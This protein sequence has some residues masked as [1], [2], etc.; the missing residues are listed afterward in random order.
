MDADAENLPPLQHVMPSAEWLRARKARLAEEAEEAERA[1]TRSWLDEL[2]ARADAEIAAW[3]TYP[4]NGQLEQVTACADAHAKGCD[5]R[6][7]DVCPR[8][9]LAEAAREEAWKRRAFRGDL[10]RAGVPERALQAVWDA[11][12]LQTK[13]VA[14]LREALARRPAPLFVVLAGGVGT[15]KSC[16]AALWLVER[17]GGAWVTA[18]ELARIGAY[19]KD[20]RARLEEPNLV[21]DDLGVEYL[22]GKDYLLANVDDLISARYDALRPMVITT[23]LAATDFQARYGPRVW[24][25]LREVGAWAKVDGASLRSRR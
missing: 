3:A 4:C 9:R 18:A 5:R 23:N 2:R 1:D 12:P 21:L 16:A 22:D 8:R 11:P 25:R 15:G 10:V 20:A 14:A 7:R 6:D 24:D 19:D 17:G 13:A